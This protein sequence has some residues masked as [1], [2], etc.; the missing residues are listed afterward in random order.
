[1][2]ASPPTDRS[3][4]QPDPGAVQGSGPLRNLAGLD[5][6]PGFLL[7]LAQRHAFQVF[8]EFLGDSGLSPRLYSTLVLI[9]MNPGCRQ[10]DIGETLGVLQTNLVKRIDALVDRGLVVRGRDPNDRRSKTL[11][12]TAD[13][14]AFARSARDRHADMLTGMRTRMGE[15]DMTGLLALLARFIAIEAERGGRVPA[16][17]DE[18]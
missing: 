12:L 17:I 3:F 2:A 8:D 9:E 10:V 13:G 4:T 16:L 15:E 14:L 7:S 18:A 6:T 11:H 1:M 5:E